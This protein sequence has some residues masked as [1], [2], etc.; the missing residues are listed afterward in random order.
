MFLCN[1]NGYS[2]DISMY[3]EVT[4]LKSGQVFFQTFGTKQGPLDGLVISTPYTTKVCYV[5]SISVSVTGSH[6]RLKSYTQPDDHCKNPSLY[7]LVS[8]T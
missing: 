8:V 6:R 3:K 1:E 5:M 2:L 7:S 4:D